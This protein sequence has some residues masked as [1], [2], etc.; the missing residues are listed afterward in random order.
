[1]LNCGLSTACLEWQKLQLVKQQIAMEAAQVASAQAKQ[2]GSS[3]G[4]TK[5]SP[6][7]QP[8][9]IIGALLPVLAGSLI[10]H[11]REMKL[12]VRFRIAARIVGWDKKNIYVESLFIGEHDPAIVYAQALSRLS[13][14]A[15]PADE[16]MRMIG[17]PSEPPA[18]LPAHV[19]HFKACQLGMQSDAQSQIRIQLAQKLAQESIDLRSK[20]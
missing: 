14:G 2:K 3:D 16:I 9:K 17:A 6:P 20:L 13:C 10:R 15:A 5:Q 7:A 1:M 11:K 19:Q 4:D 12:W 18:S 8:V